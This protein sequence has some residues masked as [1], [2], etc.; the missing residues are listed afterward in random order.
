M[1]DPS[2]LDLLG[3]VA[4]DDEW[5]S[6]QAHR[7]FFV[8]PELLS[9]S[10]HDRLRAEIA[11]LGPGHDR[12]LDALSSAERTREAVETDLD[13][14]PQVA[15]PI[16]R[17]AEDLRVGRID[18]LTALEQARAHHEA[19]T[20]PSYVRALALGARQALKHGDW[21]WA[22]SRLDLLI[23][24]LD[25]RPGRAEADAAGREV[26]LDR[27]R[28]ARATIL[29]VG[30]PVA[31]RAG[32]DVGE[33]LVRWAGDRDDV[34]VLGE[35]LHELGMLHSQP[36]TTRRTA[37]H[38]I[39]EAFWRSRVY[40][41]GGLTWSPGDAAL[42]DAR[43]ALEMGASHLRRAAAIRMGPDRAGTLGVLAATLTRLGELQVE[44]DPVEIVAAAREAAAHADPETHPDNALALMSLL[45]RFG[46][47]VDL[48]VVDRVLE[49]SIDE[50][51][52]RIGPE[53]TAAL[54][55]QA[56]SLLADPEPGRALELLRK[57]RG[58]VELVDLEH[59]RIRQLGQ[60]LA[61]IARVHVPDH[62][63]LAMG[64]IQQTVEA[65]DVNA[66]DAERAAA[67]FVAQ[68]TRASDEREEEYGLLLLDHARKIAA[69][70][71][72]EHSAPL[73]WLEAQLHTN[74]GATKAETGQWTECILPYATA[75]KKHLDMGMPDR[76]LGLLHRIADAA[77]EGGK[78]AA[79]EA[80]GV[81]AMRALELET[82]FGDAGTARLQSVYRVVFPELASPGRPVDSEMFGTAAQLAKG[83]S[84]A[85][86]LFAGGPI[87]FGHGD[88]DVGSELLKE[89]TELEDA[90]PPTSSA[91]SPSREND[92]LLLV[93]YAGAPRTRG[94]GEQ[95]ERL[96]NLRASYD[97][98]VNRRL[99]SS[100]GTRAPAL[101][102][103]SDVRWAIGERT[104]LLDIILNRTRDG[105][106]TATTS[107]YVRGG[108]PWGHI[109]V[110][111]DPDHLY[112]ISGE[113]AGVVV[114]G[115]G[116]RVTDLL[117]ELRAP[118]DP[119]LV[120]PRAARMLADHL[121]IMSPTLREQLGEWRAAGKDHLCVVPHGP[122]HYVPFH[123]FGPESRPLA[124]DWIVTYLPA[125]QLITAAR[126]TPG[127]VRRREQK[128][129]SLGMTYVESN[130]YHLPELRRAGEEAAA[131]AALYGAT[132]RVDADVTEWTVRQALG[133]ALYVHIAAH[134][135][136]DVDAPAFQCLYL[137]P[138]AHSDGRLSAH[139]LL[140]RNLR[141]T[142]VLTLSACETALGRFD[143]AGNLR[144]LPASFL[145]GGVSTIVGTL[146]P[147]EDAAAAIF[148]PAFHGALRDGEPRLDA[149]AA[150]QRLTRERYPSYRSWGPFCYL[151]EWD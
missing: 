107:V 22:A 103:P 68:A 87:S 115:F 149:F 110:Q 52:R 82:R 150:A 111:A 16:E 139:E 11:E 24:A 135:R 126:G 99:L 90:A 100:V 59:Y 97:A 121:H 83:L 47:P 27:I 49:R 34:G 127:A 85:T 61:L 45:H 3:Q 86:A 132:E 14:Y 145:L 60:A 36:W 104:V 92:P 56:A 128:I 37:D 119:D 95:H 23:A 7:L 30:D 6:D 137:T 35:S 48:A 12:L 124:E 131:I 138:K 123:L 93:A 26:L 18:Q 122:L 116:P 64:S 78:G 94:G 101:V 38:Q 4:G 134:G 62:R 46:E 13:R 75:L 2:A 9:A 89:I 1:P 33:R 69:A 28:T 55:E 21:Q 31:L 57:G 51:V 129:A 63:Q 120:R 19:V 66:W 40:D 65:A 50:W 76:A 113:H 43:S 144:G 53:S 29:E 133:D 136:I 44:V 118:A 84:F 72:A 96:A 39:D 91:M 71:A 25:A 41:L 42:P 148:F 88:D 77:R 105:Q 98:H 5:S 108:E 143:Y 20:A 114:S 102:S 15:G 140:G 147:V 151:G 10:V 80:V 73:D 117:R 141:G 32:V 142:Q 125:V 112:E 17:I 130:P 8:H 58:V 70:F 81:L 67:F 74:H 106:Q 79:E 54:V 146:W 109:A